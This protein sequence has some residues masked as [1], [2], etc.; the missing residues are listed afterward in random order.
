MLK[1]DICLFTYQ[2]FSSSRMFRPGQDEL[3]ASASPS[4][5]HR[6]T[7]S[8]SIY[9]PVCS[10]TV[11]LNR[12]RCYRSFP[13]LSPSGILILSEEGALALRLLQPVD[14]SCPT[15]NIKAHQALRSQLYRNVKV[16]RLKIPKHLWRSPTYSHRANASLPSGF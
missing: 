9:S 15:S 4:A 6:G 7:I 8:P 5:V 11:L 2:I 14:G 10:I 3:Q 1:F 12:A 13:A 16:Q